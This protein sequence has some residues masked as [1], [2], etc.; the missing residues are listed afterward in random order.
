MEENKNI[1]G[2]AFIRP[3]K[4]HWNIVGLMNWSNPHQQVV[5]IKV[6][7]KEE[8]NAVQRLLNFC[9]W[10]PSSQNCEWPLF[11]RFTQPLYS[12]NSLLMIEKCLHRAVTTFVWPLPKNKN[13]WLAFDVHSM[14]WFDYIL[15]NFGF[16][17][18]ETRIRIFPAALHFSKPYTH[19]LIS[20]FIFFKAQ[21]FWHKFPL[22]L[23]FTYYM[24]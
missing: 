10:G 2:N 19:I 18:S 20:K 3:W 14:F 17:F 1:Y 16:Y 13:I 6:G 9:Q 23:M 15:L 7:Y 22:D 8:V 24:H 11:A 4:S 12:I 21:K 5:F